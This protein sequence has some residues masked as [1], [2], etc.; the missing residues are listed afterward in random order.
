MTDKFCKDCRHLAE[1]FARDN[2]TR[3]VALRRKDLVHGAREAHL[4]KAAWL[5]RAEMRPMFKWLFRDQCGPEG[6][7]FEPKIGGGKSA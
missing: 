5:E 1:K 7:Y 2:C 3:P 6:K 4:D